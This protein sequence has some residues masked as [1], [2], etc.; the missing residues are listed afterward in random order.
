MQITTYLLIMLLG[1][2]LCAATHAEMSVQR[3][4]GGRFSTS[5]SIEGTPFFPAEVD[6]PEMKTGALVSFSVPYTLDVS[7]YY[8]I[9]TKM[10]TRIENFVSRYGSAHTQV[11]YADVTFEYTKKIRPKTLGVWIS[12][13]EYQIGVF[14]KEVFNARLDGLYDR[15]RIAVSD[16]DSANSARFNCAGTFTYAA[17]VRKEVF[18]LSLV[19]KAER[20]TFSCLPVLSQYSA[21]GSMLFKPSASVIYN[22]VEYGFDVPRDDGTRENSLQ[23][24]YSA[25][26][27]A[28]SFEVTG[29]YTH[30]LNDTTKIALTASYMH[31]VIFDGSF[32]G[33]RNTYNAV[34]F[35]YDVNAFVIEDIDP[36]N[37]AKTVSKPLTIKKGITV[38]FPKKVGVMLSHAFTPAVTLAITPS[39]Y[40]GEF[41]YA[42]DTSDKLI[43]DGMEAQWGG[44]VALTAWY[45]DIRGS[46]I[47]GKGIISRKPVYIPDIQ[48]AVKLP[49][50]KQY[51]VKLMFFASVFP[52]DE[53]TVMY[54]K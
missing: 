24:E 25:Q 23:Q 17:A 46:V 44:D 18:G 51:I 41:A 14:W 32:K 50:M 19:Y 10:N 9:E 48:L 38:K 33:I 29:T 3:I 52:N 49:I 13:E 47:A 12:G 16:S 35:N 2:A 27:S 54:A 1:S 7:P 31:D 21:D 22:G 53:I 20:D 39:L 45:A 6:F 4:D 43:Y 15:F 26:Y 42:I 34:W 8:D 28:T 5:G 40:T 37:P 30:S 11:R 36:E